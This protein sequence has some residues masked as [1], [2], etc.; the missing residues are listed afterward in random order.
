MLTQVRHLPW[1]SSAQAKKYRA[2]DAQDG[3]DDVNFLTLLLVMRPHIPGPHIFLMSDSSRT[4]TVDAGSQHASVCILA[5]PE[6]L[7]VN[8][9]DITIL[10]FLG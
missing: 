10:I 7:L 4:L 2:P 6:S 9:M 8:E 5:L 1:H 3:D